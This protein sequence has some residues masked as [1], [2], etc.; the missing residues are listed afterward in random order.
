MTSDP[1]SWGSRVCRFRA[2]R[3]ARQDTIER[4]GCILRWRASVRDPFNPVDSP[5]EEA[6]PQVMG[7]PQC[8]FDSG[9]TG[10]HLSAC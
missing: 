4:S 8:W 1:P 7:D 3:R 6:G 9:K 10:V 5:R 2:C